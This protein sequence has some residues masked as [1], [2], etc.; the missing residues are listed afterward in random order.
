MPHTLFFPNSTFGWVFYLALASITLLASYWD[1]KKLVIPKKLS[2][3]ALGLGMLFNVTR[4]AWLG[5]LGKTVWLWEAPTAGHGAM[6]GAA[7][8]FAGFGVGFGLF[9]LLWALGTCG[10]GDVKLMAALGAWIGPLWAVYILIGSWF[11]VVFMTFVL[12]SGQRVAAGKIYQ[13]SRKIAYSFPVAL[14]TMVVLLW[15][16][17]AELFMHGPPPPAAIPGALPARR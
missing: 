3:G 14:S 9:F 10:G 6:H 15:V 2:L 8:A 13:K 17:R 5:N 7:F 1:W 4:G 16:F 12:W 11:V